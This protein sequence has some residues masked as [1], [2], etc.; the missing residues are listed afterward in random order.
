MIDGPK[1]S[2]W[3]RPGAGFVA[4][5]A[6]AVLAAAVPARAQD[7]PVEVRTAAH[8]ALSQGRYADAIRY[9]NQ[10]VTWFSDD[11]SPSIVQELEGVYFNLGLC[12]LLLGDFDDAREVFQEYL[13]RY[14]RESRAHLVAAYIGD[15]HRYQEDFETALQAYREALRQYVYTEDVLS[16][17]L[18]AKVRCHLAE[19][20]W[21]EATPLLQ[22][23]YRIAPDFR[24]RNWAATM[25]T[26]AHLKE[27]NLDPVFRMVPILL[28]PDSFAAF[29]VALNM[30]ALET[31]DELFAEERYREALWLYR[32]VYPHDVLMHNALTRRDR[33]ERRIDF[34]RRIPG[35]AIRELLRLQEMLSETEAEI[36]ALEEIPNYDGELF[37]RI[38]RSYFETRR[39]REASELFYDLYVDGPRDRAEESLYLSFLAATR[40]QPL[41]RAF[42]RGGE[43]MDEYPGGR[44][45]DPVSLTL[46]QLY[47]NL[48]D[49]PN[50]I[51]VLEK[52][53][54]VS[55]EHRELVECLFLLGYAYFMEEQFPASVERLV[56][57][58]TEF[59][60]NAREAEG[61]YW[62]GMALL[63]D[64]EYERARVYFDRVVEDFST[65]IFVEDSTFRSAVCDFAL[66]EHRAAEAKLLGFLSTYPESVLRAE[67]Y[68]ILGDISG[69]FGELEE[70]VRRFRRAVAHEEQLNIEL[71]N[72]AVFRCG[73]ILSEM[74]QFEEVIAHFNRYIERDRPESNFALAIY[75]IGN[76][77]WELDRRE[78]ALG[79]FQR[80]IETYGRD[81]MELGIDLIF[82]E[83][84]GRTRRAGGELEAQAW[85]Q[86]RELLYRAQDEGA[87]TLALRVQ[88]ILPFDPTASEREQA[89]HREAL[90]NEANLPHA[91]PG[92]LEM[93][94]HEA[95]R[96]GNEALA[97]AAAREIVATFTETDYALTARALLA[98]EAVA[99]EDYAEAIVHLDIIREVFAASEEAANALMMLGRIYMEQRRFEE[100][101]EAFRDVLGVR[102]WRA[103]WPEALF[104]RGEVARA[105]RRFEEAAA[106]Y[107][108]I[109]VLYSGHREWAARAYL[110]RA[111]TLARLQEING[112]VETLEE[113]LSQEDLAARPE[114]AQARELMERFRR[115]I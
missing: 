99:R 50:T 1:I 75:W 27:M 67:A 10:L 37:F 84:V 79:T 73:E 69:V 23:L 82:E 57:M 72:Y 7:T 11:R 49:W 70:A 19:D 54:E 44:W 33:I 24:R 76:A 28:A 104:R 80:A 13:R 30:T 77:H 113:M 58:N 87:T 46:G 103:W 17:I 32:L 102:E 3:R 101:D 16:D 29:S 74:R 78:R 98:E 26:V 12:H 110:A 40:F 81:R 39:Y 86:M 95:N 94:V 61:T 64:K 9:L 2:G 90:L 92:V 56:R 48:R 45:Y 5:L 93:I 43:Y 55:P 105:R 34:L 52:A 31:A 89:L 47:A 112:A 100:A 97:L 6:A 111:E 42:A 8:L 59:P 51:R 108:R 62:T 60:G 65:S 4:V 20:R 15:T 36:A 96:D 106:Y 71:Y 68:V 85:A 25:L 114:G 21:R 109:Y 83:W 91:S 38:A 53:L 35:D 22:R 88:R 107:E 18:L 41:D 63:F 115:R 14:R 66:G